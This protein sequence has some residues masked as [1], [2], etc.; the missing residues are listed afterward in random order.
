[1]SDIPDTYVLLR[2]SR[3]PRTR[4]QLKA[5]LEPSLREIL[6]RLCVWDDDAN[7]GDYRFCVLSYDLPEDVHIFL[8]FWSEPRDAVLWE[9]SSGKWNP[10]TEPYMAG[11][12]ASRVKAAG[13][14]MGG[15]AQN[16]QKYVDVD[17]LRDVAG[18]TRQVI[19]LLYDALDYRGQQALTV[20][21]VADSRTTLRP[22]YASIEP[23]DLASILEDAGYT[24]DVGDDD[25]LLVK[26]GLEPPAA[27]PVS[28]RRYGIRAVA[29]L[30]AQA[31]DDGGFEVIA[32][33]VEPSSPAR[34]TTAR[35]ESIEMRVLWLAG[36]VTASWLQH[37]F[38]DWFND[39][40]QEKKVKEPKRAPAVRAKTS[41]SV[42]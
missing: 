1:M 26:A 42:H 18:L 38:A 3:R 14:K 30:L 34:G 19:A 35:A 20:Q 17:T 6:T 15:N 28:V 21:A 27:V 10:P 32:L 24:C 16:Y 12:R 22:V 41:R 37:Q 13:F 39:Q 29:W 9:V 23:D 2:A 5:A 7:V 4:A 11:T 33:G 25:D 31:P 36:G 40:R 8:Q